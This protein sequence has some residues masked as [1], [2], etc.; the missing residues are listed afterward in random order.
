MNHRNVLG[1]L[2][3]GLVLAGRK[4]EI[5]APV[6]TSTGAG[7]SGASQTGLV[8]SSSCNGDITPGR[9]PLPRLTRVEHA[10]TVRDL[11]G[12]A[13]RGPLEVP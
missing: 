8:M 4:G 3:V 10:N 13:G 2:G 7:S 6:S 11:L 5:G 1:V 9:A 12:A